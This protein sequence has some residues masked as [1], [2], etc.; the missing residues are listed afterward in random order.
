MARRRVRPCCRPIKSWLRFG[1]HPDDDEIY[2]IDSSDLFTLSDRAV[3]LSRATVESDIGV[4]GLTL[5][6]LDSARAVTALQTVQVFVGRSSRRLFMLI[7]RAATDQAKI[8]F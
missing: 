1:I 4:Y 6:I 5:R 3:V 8:R 7:G 2:E